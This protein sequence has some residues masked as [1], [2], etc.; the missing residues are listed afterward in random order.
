MKSE[1]ITLTTQSG[2]DSFTVQM[3]RQFPWWLLL[4]LPLILLWPMERLFQLKFVEGDL[5]TPVALT[6]ASIKYQNIKTFG[7]HVDSAFVSTTTEQGLS[8]TIRVSEPLWHWLFA[9][10]GDSVYVSI[11]NGCAALR[12]TICYNDFP[13]DE[14][15]QLKL[16]EKMRSITMQVVDKDSGE[17]I[18]N[19]SVTVTITDRYG[20]T[21]TRQ[22]TT[23][24]NGYFTMEN[25]PICGNAKIHAQ[26]DDYYDNSAE[27]PTADINDGDQ[28]PLK[29][30]AIPRRCCVHFSGLVFSDYFS[31][32]P[33]I[34]K[35]DEPDRYTDY[36]SAGNYPD[37][38]TAFPK[39]VGTSFDGIAVFKGTHLT[40]YSKPN[41]QGEILLDVSGPYLI[42][43]GKWKNDNRYSSSLSKT[44]SPE[45]EE[46]F[47]PS[48]RHWSTSNM[49][50]WSNGS[51]KITCE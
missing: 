49:Q 50:D 18:P 41:F 22:Y 6:P 1:K 21:E 31:N 28:I 48:C 44:F 8:D 13:K 16:A 26:H 39:A 17:P 23:D 30:P 46:A 14:P 36:V 15:L 12:D 33:G 40:I 5:N 42:N 47:P 32:P 35:I 27:S 11:D 2:S 51:C 24:S 19:A 38:K 45:L 25:V 43:N 4:L 34:S 20:R 37:N 9:G 3:K 29:K 10:S 7:G